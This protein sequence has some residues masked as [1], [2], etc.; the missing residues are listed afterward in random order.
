MTRPLSS[1]QAANVRQVLAAQADMRAAE[2]AFE[3]AM[4]RGDADEIN[5][6]TER[7]H[8]RAQAHLDAVAAQVA[9]SL[10]RNGLG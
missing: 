3:A 7:V 1:E 2:A 5:A 8:Q 10:R 4:W 9:I 6:A